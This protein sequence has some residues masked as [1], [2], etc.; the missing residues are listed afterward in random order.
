ML[1]TKLTDLTVKQVVAIGTVLYVLK[2]TDRALAMV[3]GRRAN[4]WAEKK[5]Q[6]R[7][8]KRHKLK[9]ENAANN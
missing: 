3:Y 5:K 1:N 6:E 9:I 8:K 2:A 4:E 7:L